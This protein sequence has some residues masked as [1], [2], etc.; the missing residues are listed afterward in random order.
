MGVNFMAIAAEA[1]CLFFM[2]YHSSQWVFIRAASK[3]AV[4]IPDFSNPW[5][6]ETPDV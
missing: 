5:G 6:Y 1:Y 3:W 2:V 4:N